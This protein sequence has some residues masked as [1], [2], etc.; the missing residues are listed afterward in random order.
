MWTFAISHL[1]LFKVV[2][3]PQFAVKLPHFLLKL[4][5]VLNSIQTK[6]V[7][8]CK[9]WVI[10]VH[11]CQKGKE[12]T[13]NSKVTYIS[14]LGNK[15]PSSLWT[16]TNLVTLAHASHFPSCLT[17]EWHAFLLFY[18]QHS[19]FQ[20]ITELQARILLSI[21]TFNLEEPDTRS[22]TWANIFRTFLCVC[23][24]VLQDGSKNSGFENLV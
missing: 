11:L 16:S 17:R 20:V 1:F 8:W 21:Y 12:I 3:F 13:S 23:T 6:P 7:L 2:A 18:Q 5:K 4:L 24:L 10:S 22:P 9:S 19:C 14:I 15:S